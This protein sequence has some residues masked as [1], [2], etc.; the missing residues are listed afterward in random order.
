MSFWSINN[1]K[2][3]IYRA[4]CDPCFATCE[5]HCGH[6]VQCWEGAGML[7]ISVI[8]L[9]LERHSLPALGNWR[10]EGGKEV[11]SV[12][13]EPGRPGCQWMDELP[14][15]HK[16]MWREAS[17]VPLVIHSLI[18]QRVDW[19]LARKPGGFPQFEK[20]HLKLGLRQKVC[21]PSVSVTCTEGKLLPLWISVSA[22]V[23]GYIIP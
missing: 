11:T 10:V 8:L 4:V 17:R 3:K 21:I 20:R 1:K 18:Q 9:W 23:S 2:K 5:A 12:V 6:G 16:Q 15:P 13:V 14:C 22:P 7:V 19:P